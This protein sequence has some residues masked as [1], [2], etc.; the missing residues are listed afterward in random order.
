MAVFEDFLFK[1]K[2]VKNWTRTFL[3]WRPTII[4]SI[5]TYGT[6]WSISSVENKSPGI[7]CCGETD[8][9]TVAV[10]VVVAAAVAVAGTG[11]EIS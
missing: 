9:A 10:L 1:W 4:S 7:R 3:N 6:E 2:T 5:L 11:A 8:S